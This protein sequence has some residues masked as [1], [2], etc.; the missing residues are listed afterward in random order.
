MP[1]IFDQKMPSTL[2]SI[3]LDTKELPDGRVV[4][5][6]LPNGDYR[7]SFLLRDPKSRDVV[8]VI[9]GF[10]VD[11]DWMQILT[12]ASRGVK[13]EIFHFL[14]FTP[15]FLSEVMR[16]LLEEK[17][18]FREEAHWIGRLALGQR[19]MDE[20][21]EELAKLPKGLSPEEAVEREKEIVGRVSE[22]YPDP[23]PYQGYYPERELLEK[24]DRESEPIIGCNV[25]ED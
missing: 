12:P 2:W 9:E 10:R 14:K 17:A 16:E 8:G 7:F 6:K 25:G 13:G 1:S 21:G 22:K 5:R 4:L 23:G 20:I 24:R 11:R 15:E 18:R 19:K 3:Q